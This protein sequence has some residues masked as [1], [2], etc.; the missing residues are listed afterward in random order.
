MRVAP[1]VIC[2]AFA[3]PLAA[4]QP[5]P[6]DPATAP[7]S[8]QQAAPSVPG[9]VAPVPGAPSPATPANTLTQN[10]RLVILD[11]VVIDKKGNAVTDLKREEFHITEND[12]PEDIRNFEV[13]G[14]FM[15][16]PGVTISS[17]ADL[18]RL[19]PRAPVNI[20]LLDEFNT[21]F[22]DM[23][24]ARYSLKKWLDKQPAKLDTPCMLVAVDL[25]HFA[26]LRDYT[27][28]KDEILN[29][30]NHHFAAY[31]WQA[32]QFAWVAERYTTAF[33]ALTRVAEATVGH[34]GHKNMIW[35]G[36]GF[37]TIN[38]ATVA[39]DGQ[40]QIHSAMQQTVNELRD[41][42]VTL[43]TIDPAGLMMDAGVYGN[44]A[45][46]FSP[47]GGDPTFEELA[48]ATGGRTLHGR[49]DVDAE[50]GGAIRD[51]ASLYTLTYRPATSFNEPEKFR[52]IR[53]TLDR[54][55]LTFVTR[56]GY[57][58]ATRPAR[59]RADGQVGRKLAT[60]LIN[61]GDSNMAYDAVAF[62]VQ[63]SAT[64]AN[65]LHV[66]VEPRG[67][68]WYIVPDGSKPRF[69]RLIVLTSEFD[70]KGKELSRKG[71]TYTFTAPATAPQTG[72]LSIP[73]GVKV[74]LDPQP[75]AVRARIVVR[76]EASG[77]MGTADLTL[78]PGASAKSSSATAAAAPAAPAP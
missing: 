77:H 32:H 75:K 28:N 8:A 44:A 74:R 4:Q 6:T 33:N 38:L 40:N 42:R 12:Q 13:P 25:Q 27:Q 15:P 14:R 30:L 43:Y 36:R 68:A 47:F 63:A 24:F 2:L 20:V 65:D 71:A 59:P 67:M 39:L 49:N 48:S 1:I 37:P 73:V 61:A 52:R 41:A 17:T 10:V 66:S 21:R 22:E 16:D 55:G 64:D 34:Q 57:Y 60:E 62:S 45:R 72:P 54:P 76:I 3:L 69:T 56:Q 53:V 51:G 58:P 11:G 70:K 35:L 7:P 19:A 50:I 18:D 78:G 5:A 26:V 46:A 9:P 29:A 31:P 23:A